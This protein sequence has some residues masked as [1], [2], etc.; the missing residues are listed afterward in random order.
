MVVTNL[1]H[2]VSVED[3]EE[4][5]DNIGTLKSARL[6]RVGFAEVVFMNQEDALKSVEVYHNRQLDGQPM[7]VTLVAKKAPP[8][9][10]APL[11]SSTSTTKSILKSARGRSGYYL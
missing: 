2:V 5:F 7:N 9:L 6:V 4:L 1:H 11:P 8:A 3:I 10:V